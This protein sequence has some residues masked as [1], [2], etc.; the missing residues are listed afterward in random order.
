MS[1]LP[2]DPEDPSSVLPLEAL[3]LELASELLSE[4]LPELPLS[5]EDPDEPELEP[6]LEPESELVAPESEVDT[7]DETSSSST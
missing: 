2:V 7:D 1:V 5:L 6:E 3:P 4:A